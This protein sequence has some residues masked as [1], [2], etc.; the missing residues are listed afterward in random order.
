[1]D[2]ERQQ[3]L[4]QQDAVRVADLLRQDE[5]RQ[6][7]LRSQAEIIRQEGLRQAAALQQEQHMLQA[8]NIRREEERIWHMESQQAEAF[9][10]TQQYQPHHA[11]EPTQLYPPDLSTAGVAPAAPPCEQSAPADVRQGDQSGSTA[12]ADGAATPAAA[13]AR[14]AVHA[15]DDDS[16]QSIASDITGLMDFD[17][18]ATPERASTEGLA[19]TRSPRAPSAPSSRR[20]RTA[21]LSEGGVEVPSRTAA[22][23]ATAD[24]RQVPFPRANATTKQC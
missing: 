9:A 7:D 16:D 21:L 17:S 23:R 12:P 2:D 6:Q 19:R 24:H 20:G 10:A 1:M 8:E 5:M 13:H 14:P 18:P 11:E 4:R 3:D 15:L 22:D